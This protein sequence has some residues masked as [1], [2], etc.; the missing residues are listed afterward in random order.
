M[1]LPKPLPQPV[2][3]STPAKKVEKHI[4][5]PKGDAVDLS[6]EEETE[7]EEE[8]EN[9]LENTAMGGIQNTSVISTI[10]NEALPKRGALFNWAHRKP[11]LK[12]F[13]RSNTYIHKG[14][15]GENIRS[16]NFIFDERANQSFSTDG[17]LVIDTATQSHPT[18]VMDAQAT[19][20]QTPT[21]MQRETR[22]EAKQMEYQKWLELN[23]TLTQGCE[24]FPFVQ[25]ADQTKFNKIIPNLPASTDFHLKDDT[26]YIRTCFESYAKYILWS[27]YRREQSDRVHGTTRYVYLTGSPFIGKS[28]FRHYFLQYYTQMCIDVGREVTVY[29]NAAAPKGPLIGPWYRWQISRDKGEWATDNRGDRLGVHRFTY[30]TAKVDEKTGLSDTLILLD[31]Y[32]TKTNLALPKGADIVFFLSPTEYV[33][34]GSTRSIGHRTL[35]FPAMGLD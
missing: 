27:F 16:S 8:T 11:V 3:A 24:L 29:C 34:S 17:N 30:V 26:Y 1:S 33:Q 32:P 6:I 21:P 12:Q 19:P 7:T 20:R 35:I 22:R 25:N 5:G 14:P 18:V 4:A 23:E 15:C 28:I 10:E 2:A 31:G 13:A 9:Q